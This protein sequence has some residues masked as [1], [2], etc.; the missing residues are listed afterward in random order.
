M[1]CTDIGGKA[2]ICGFA[3]IALLVIVFVYSI[4]VSESESRAYGL[5]CTN[6]GGIHLRSSNRDFCI[7]E[8]LPLGGSKE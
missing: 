4:I 7:K 1:S 3:I 6:A 8:F 5:R 2:I